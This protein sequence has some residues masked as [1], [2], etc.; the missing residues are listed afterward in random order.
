MHRRVYNAVA[1]D[2]LFD[3]SPFTS[4]GELAPFP[5]LHRD[6]AQALLENLWDG[7]NKLLLEDWNKKQPIYRRK[8]V[9]LWLADQDWVDAQE[10][11]EMEEAWS[12]S[13]TCYVLRLEGE[14]VKKS[15]KSLQTPLLL[16]RVRA[17]VKRLRITPT[18]QKLGSRPRSFLPFLL[19]NSLLPASLPR[20]ESS[21]GPSRF[22][23]PS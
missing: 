15:Y 11:E 5:Q 19:K 1:N 7:Q 10:E 20:I 16:K 18:E 14:R 21:L 2:A 6:I 13:S 3:P 4:L 9:R 23:P 8:A 12:F 22:E 17:V